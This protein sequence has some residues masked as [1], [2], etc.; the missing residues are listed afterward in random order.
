V[1][2]PADRSGRRLVAAYGAGL[3]FAL[4]LGLAGMT[5]PN[6]IL[7]FLDL[8]GG[9]WDPSLLL[10]MGGALAVH[11]A[12][13]A[14]IRRR[15]SPLLAP[16][17]YLP[18]RREISASLLGG[19]AIFGVGWGLSGYCPG[20]AV[21]SLASGSRSVLTFTSGMLLGFLLHALVRAPRPISAPRRTG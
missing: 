5:N 17:F 9:H 4:G 20:P 11:A 1:R 3:L 10:V 12:S 18:A 19:A 2:A 21:V 16:R 15:P 13:Y 7:A 14:V 6:R 8:F